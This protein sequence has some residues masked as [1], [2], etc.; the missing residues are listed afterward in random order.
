M[1]RRRHTHSFRFTAPSHTHTHVHGASRRTHVHVHIH[2]TLIKRTHVHGASRRT[3]VH[4]HVHG[5]SRRTHVSDWTGPLSVPLLEFMVHTHGKLVTTPLACLG[6]GDCRPLPT[7]PQK[8]S[9]GPH[10][11]TSPPPPS[12]PRAAPAPPLAQLEC[13]CVDRCNRRSRLCVEGGAATKGTIAD[14]GE[15]VW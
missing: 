8:S 14:G 6:V 10:A 5:A 2:G 13:S 1:R 7:T 11:H 15:A 12:S 3:H 4:V 9:N